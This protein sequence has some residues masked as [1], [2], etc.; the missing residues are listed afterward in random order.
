MTKNKGGRPIKVTPE[1]VQKLEEAFI[2]G[3][4]DSEAC[5]YA[6]IGMS[7]LYDYC[8]KNPKFSDKKET[9]K[10]MPVM[11]ARFIVF[12]ELEDKSVAQANK[13][14]DRSEG[15]KVKISGDVEN[16]LTLAIMEISGNTLE[17]NG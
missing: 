17:P 12:D 15:Q 13:V 14:I 10:N 2:R 11:K 7:T 8:A 16:P 1:C 9:L 3:C 4:T 5:C 6:D